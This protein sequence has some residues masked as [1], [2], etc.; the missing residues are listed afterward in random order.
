[1]KLVDL[2]PRLF[3]R[4]GPLAYDCTDAIAEADALLMKCPACYW[5]AGRTN[6]T[7]DVHALIVWG[8]P[9]WRFTGKDCGDLSLGIAPARIVITAGHTRFTIKRGVVDFY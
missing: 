3:K 2:D 4:A 8:D 9:K 1:M 7:F 6:T 5:S